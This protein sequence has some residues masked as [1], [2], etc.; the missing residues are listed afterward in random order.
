MSRWGHWRIKGLGYVKTSQVACCNVSVP[1]RGTVEGEVDAG[2]SGE[3]IGL[4]YRTLVN[5]VR[6]VPYR[7]GAG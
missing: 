4:A 2:S 5:G 1:T 7:K 3:P 6:T